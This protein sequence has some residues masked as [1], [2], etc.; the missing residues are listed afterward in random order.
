MTRLMVS[1]GE[2]SGDLIAGLMV[3]ELRAL[4][5]DLEVTGVAGQRLTRAGITPIANVTELSVMGLFEVIG[6]LGRIKRVL[7]RLI[8]ALDQEV[9][10]LV[11]VDF[12]GF[13][14]RLAR[15]AK[16]RDI[17]VVFYV[18]PQVWAWRHKRAAEISKLAK[19]VLCLLPFEPD[20]YRAVGGNASFVGHPL[21][22]S[23]NRE[24]ETAGHW[25][26]LPGS[27]QAEIER[28][29]P[30]MVAVARELRS[31]DANAKF[32][33]GAAPGWDAERLSTVAKVDLSNIEVVD[34]LEVGAQGAKAA[35]V[36]SG[37]ATLQLGCR[38]IPMVVIYK[39][40]PFTHW[41]LRRI[42]KGVDRIALPNIVL[43]RDVVPEFIQKLP[44]IEIADALEVASLGEQVPALSDLR[45]VMSSENAS[46]A[47]A[48]KVE[49]WLPTLG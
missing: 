15:A 14:I 46:R 18:S 23:A 2:P 7:K 29:L 38:S 9:D 21:A 34:G 12:S 42:V 28:L 1:V 19:E 22:V 25:L 45:E 48:I 10:L 49:S 5:P 20:V 27:R 41:L 44:P 4:R 31:R 26:L 40:N 13:N 17:P 32:R 33:L 16:A 47:A 11:V 8:S 3:E 37:T 35:L 39:V 24:L 43:G 6:S 30:V 36:S